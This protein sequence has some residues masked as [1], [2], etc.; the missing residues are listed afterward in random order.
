[1]YDIGM[2]YKKNGRYYLAV[3]TNKLLSFVE[4]QPLLFR[5][6]KGLQKDHLMSVRELCTVW[7]ITVET[8]DQVVDKFLLSRLQQKELKES[9]E[10]PPRDHLIATG[11]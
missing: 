3:D 11:G 4:G 5:I 8:L 6:R 10:P 2:V 1:M 7:G 9:V